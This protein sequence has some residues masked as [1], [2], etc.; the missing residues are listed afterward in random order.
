M[1]E[2]YIYMPDLITLYLIHNILHGVNIFEQVGKANGLTLLL[3]A[4]TFDYTFHRH[5]SEGFKIAVEHHLDQPLMS[6]K[7][8]DITPG[9]ET[10]VTYMW[11]LQ[12]IDG[13]R[14]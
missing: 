11:Y 4:N 7:E 8:L 1:I 5:A 9:L 12:R 6:M 14:F 10:Q 2:L 13:I 3:D